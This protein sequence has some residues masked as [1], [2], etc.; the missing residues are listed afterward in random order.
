MNDIFKI[1]KMIRNKRIE[2]KKLCERK[3]TKILKIRMKNLMNV[4]KFKKIKTNRHLF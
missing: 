1:E 4:K 2:N 3:E